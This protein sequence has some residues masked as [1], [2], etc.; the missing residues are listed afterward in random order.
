MVHTVA[1]TG[2][3]PAG[4]KQQLM[5]PR[6]RAFR[7][8]LFPPGERG[9]VIYIWLFFLPQLARGERLLSE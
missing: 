8:S 7:Q 2:P 4:T 6:G 5:T 3:E 1:V 9:I